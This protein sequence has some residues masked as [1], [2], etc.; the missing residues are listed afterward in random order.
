LF[1]HL[2]I[3]DQADPAAC[4]GGSKSGVER[5]TKRE[6]VEKMF[7]SILPRWG[8]RGWL[9]PAVATKGQSENFF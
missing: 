2:G 7:L 5:L 6:K 8:K 4:Q 3:K 9:C 1:S